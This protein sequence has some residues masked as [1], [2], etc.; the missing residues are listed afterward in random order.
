MGKTATKKQAPKAAPAEKIVK[1]SSIEFKNYMLQPIIAWL[2][3]PQHG[4]KARAR[5]RVV[6]LIAEKYADFEKERLALVEKYSKKDDDGKSVLEETGDENKK[7]FIIE[8]QEAFDAEWKPLRTEIAIFDILPS[9]RNDWRVVREI[10]EKSTVEMDIETT[11][12]YEAI[13][14][15]LAGV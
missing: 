8:D 4:D 11:D 3:V 5:N 12:F 14:T 15:A 7:R 6:K 2:N 1:A 10:F 13:L 9:N